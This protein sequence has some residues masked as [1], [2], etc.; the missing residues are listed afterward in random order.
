MQPQE[1]LFPTRQSDTRQGEAQNRVSNGE[2]YPLAVTQR[3]QFLP[4]AVDHAFKP[5]SS[6]EVSVQVGLCN[7]FVC[8]FFPYSC[9]NSQTP[10]TLGKAFL[11]NSALSYAARPESCRS[12]IHR[13]SSGSFLFFWSSGVRPRRCTASTTSSQVDTALSLSIRPHGVTRS[14]T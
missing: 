1:S 2:F 4:F 9:V 3:P 5:R 13:R 8:S 6:Q 10:Y 7:A 12:S 11:P 14:A